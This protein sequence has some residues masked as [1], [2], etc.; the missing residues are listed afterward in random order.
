MKKSEYP[1]TANQNRLADVIAAIQVMASFKNHIQTFGDWGTRICGDENASEYWENVFRQH[2]EFFRINI[3]K[4]EASL[5]WRHAYQKRY[6]VDLEE[7]VVLSDYQKL[8]AKKR[9]LLKRNPLTPSDIAT[10]IQAAISLHSSE[11][12]HK[13]DSRWWIP[14]VFALAGVVIGAVI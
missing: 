6:D 2:P 3:G 14:G 12:D 13:Q 7:K 1:Y 11:I 5:T 4:S 10:L 8:D 9:S